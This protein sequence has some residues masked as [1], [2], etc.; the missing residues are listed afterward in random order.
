MIVYEFTGE[1]QLFQKDFLKDGTEKE[2][3]LSRQKF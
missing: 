2:R 1:Y 3:T